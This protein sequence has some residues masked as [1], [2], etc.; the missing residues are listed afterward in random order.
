M[1][2]LKMARETRLPPNGLFVALPSTEQPL[3][4]DICQTTRRILSISPCDPD[5]LSRVLPL[6]LPSLCHPHIH[7]DKPHL[8]THPTTAHLQP[9]SNTFAEALALTSEAKAAYTLASLLKRGDQLLADSSRAGVTHARAFVE[10]DARVGDLCLRAGLRLKSRWQQHL[11]VQ[12][13]A[14]AQDPVF[15]GESAGAT[16]TLVEAAARDEGIEAIGSTPY[17]E[18]DPE[19]ARSNVD[20]AV[21]LALRVGKHLDFHLDYHLDETKE[22]LVWHVLSRL[23]GEKWTERAP[24]KTVCLGHCTRL[25]LFK[26]DEWARLKREV[27]GLPVY[28]VGLPTSDLFMMGR[29]GLSK[30][31]REDS[32]LAKSAAAAADRPRGTL[33]IPAMQ[34][35]GLKCALGVNNVGNAFTPWG[36]ADPLR[37]AS[38]GVGVYQ[39][40]TRAAAE[41][42]YGCVSWGAKEAIGALDPPRSERL[43]R[44]DSERCTLAAGDM[45]DL[46]IFGVPDEDHMEEAVGKS[47]LRWKSRAF[48]RP[49]RSVADVVWDPPQ[50]RTTAF[51]GRSINLD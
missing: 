7:L 3:C 26:A 30:G 32:D 39:V 33:Q 42:L 8:L 9:T 25:T 51:R 40:G 1:N 27:Q 11:A 20:W 21:D 37:V 29:P 22:P 48:E 18:A 50:A 5:Q 6:A 23:R 43:E 34:A 28:F 41:A 47:L 15:S 24:G 4:L 19:A 13:C 49:R 17:V 35:L 36:G 45:A 12:L 38:L 10:L 14:F 16:R 31:E 2:S 46:V 44:A